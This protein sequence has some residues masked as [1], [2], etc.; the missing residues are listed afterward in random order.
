V[1]QTKTGEIRI[2][3][4]GPCGNAMQAEGKLEGPGT[5]VSSRLLFRERLIGDISNLS[6]KSI[7]QQPAVFAAL[8]MRA[9]LSRRG[10]AV[11][12]DVEQVKHVRVLPDPDV[13]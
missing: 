4:K 12:R 1:G 13:F 10:S 5:S 6:L 2:E 9:F 8:Q 7:E 3:V 11:V